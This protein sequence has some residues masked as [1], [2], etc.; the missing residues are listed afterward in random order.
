MFNINTFKSN[1]NYLRLM[2]YVLII[3]NLILMLHLICFF[4]LSRQEWS[5]SA[6]ILNSNQMD[7]EQVKEINNSPYQSK[8]YWLLWVHC[9]NISG[10]N[11]RSRQKMFDKYALDS[12][13]MERLN[14]NMWNKFKLLHVSV[15]LDLPAGTNCLLNSARLVQLLQV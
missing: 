12:L 3:Y 4:T 15:T 13:S 10:V 7:G 9:H 2:F 14:I 11:H 1:K 8:Q 6:I 5:Y